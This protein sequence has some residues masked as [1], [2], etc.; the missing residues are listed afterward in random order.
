MVARVPHA[1]AP[2][3]GI[4]YFI[5]NAGS[6]SISSY[7]I[8]DDNTLTLVRAQAAVRPAGAFP[9]DMAYQNGYLY[10]L[11]SGS[12]DL[13]VYSQAGGSLVEVGAA[14]GLR[15]APGDASPSFASEE[16]GP[17]GLAVIPDY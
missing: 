4:F 8:E 6:D 3:N 7:R 17:V 13:I 1:G 12:G 9:L 11:F 16:G 2:N 5:A 15:S 14:Q 10:Q